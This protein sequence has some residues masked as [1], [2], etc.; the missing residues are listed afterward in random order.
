[1]LYN[2]FENQKLCKYK[3]EKKHSCKTIL[4]IKFLCVF[5]VFHSVNS[6]GDK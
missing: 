5:T 4:I 3:K 6:V 1:M 2:D